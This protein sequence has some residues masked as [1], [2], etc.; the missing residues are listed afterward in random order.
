VCVLASSV[1]GAVKR[2][3]L[4]MFC[5]TVT[6]AK[7][8]TCWR[9]AERTSPSYILPPFLFI[10]RWIVQFC[11][12]VATN[13]KKRMEYNLFLMNLGKHTPDRTYSST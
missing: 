1:L 13:K 11:T 5:Q 3:S 10:S 9:V 6:V 7:S 8:V 2:S 12:E 4:H